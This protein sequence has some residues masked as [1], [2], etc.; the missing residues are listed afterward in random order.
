[1]SLWSNLD[2]GYSM[3]EYERTRPACSARR[4]KICPRG[5]AI[6]IDEHPTI[7]LGVLLQ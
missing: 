7:A 5:G 3:P 4:R 1:M 6:E 2:G